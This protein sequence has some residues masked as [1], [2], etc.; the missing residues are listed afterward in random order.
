M[1]MNDDD[2]DEEEHRVMFV[3]HLYIYKEK[4]LALLLIIN[5]FV[6]VKDFELSILE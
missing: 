2:D 6:D 3:N 5:C 1:G 4:R